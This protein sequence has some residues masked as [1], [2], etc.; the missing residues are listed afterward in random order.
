M[1]NVH[2]IRLELQFSTV[3]QVLK[4]ALLLQPMQRICTN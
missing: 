2:R 3:R 1:I 4:S